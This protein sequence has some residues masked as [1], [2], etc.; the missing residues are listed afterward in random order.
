MNNEHFLG[1][2]ESAIFTRPTSRKR[3]GLGTRLYS[4]DPPPERGVVWA[5]IHQTHLQKEVWSGHET[6]FTRPT[7]RKRCGLGT[8]L[9]SPDPPPERGVVWAR[10]YIHQTHLQKEVWSGHETIFTRPT[11]RKRCGLGMRLLI[12]WCLRGGAF[13]FTAFGGDFLQCV[14]VLG[15]LGL[16]SFRGTIQI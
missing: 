16:S 9:Y 11:S 6:I 4:P 1:C 3:C 15:D 5:H 14:C 8:R 12:P 7:S 13:E 10:D 2:A